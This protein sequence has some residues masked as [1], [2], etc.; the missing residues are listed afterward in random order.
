M[1]KSA[2]WERQ[3]KEIERAYRVIAHAFRRA[4]FVLEDTEK[5]I[6]VYKNPPIKMFIK[7]SQISDG[8]PEIIIKHY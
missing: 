4:G 3:N 8:N 2:L 5:L 1:K 6:L 7:N